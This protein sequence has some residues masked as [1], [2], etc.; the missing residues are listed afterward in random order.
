MIEVMRD[1]RSGNLRS[2]RATQAAML[3]SIQKGRLRGVQYHRAQ[4]SVQWR[5]VPCVVAAHLN[6]GKSS[7]S[8]AYDR[9]APERDALKHLAPRC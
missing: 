8:K 9:K 7:N 5:N 2:G 4:Q 3:K 1:S 6:G